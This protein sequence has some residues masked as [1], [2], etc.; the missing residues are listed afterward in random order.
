MKNVKMNRMGGG[1]NLAFT[2]VELL[3]VIAIIGILI[4]LLLPA[5]QAAREA[6]RRMQCTNNLKQIGLGIHNFH[7]GHKALPPI[8]IFNSKGSIFCYLY[9]YIEQNALYERMTGQADG[10]LNLPNGY[11]GDQWSVD[12]LTAEEQRGFGSIS[13]YL[14]PSRHT[15]GSGFAYRDEAGGDQRQSCG[16]RCDYAAVVTKAN[17]W[18][19]A[20]YCYLA[21]RTGDQNGEFAASRPSDFIGPLRVSRPT[22]RNDRNG[23]D[24]GHQSDIIS[25]VSRDSL[26]WWSDGTSNQLVM[27][28]KFI[29]SFAVGSDTQTDK[30]WDGGYMTAWPLDLVFN[31]GRFVHRDYRSIVASPADS[32]VTAGQ[33]PSNHWGHYGFGS[34]HTGTVNFLVGDGS[35]HGIS[36]TISTTLLWNLSRVNDG[37]AASIP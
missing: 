11:H 21:T 27:G 23:S 24:P 10:L 2:L 22:F 28:E 20:E 7:D 35:V 9:P 15:A 18:Y 34:H 16:P 29:P 37:N 17:E 13:A 25:W 19:W 3:V 33:S 36:T 6:A 1:G 8:V 31:V 32:G 26:S 5:V 4:A 12:V 14:C 30:R